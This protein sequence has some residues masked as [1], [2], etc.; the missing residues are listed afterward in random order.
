MLLSLRDCITRCNSCRIAWPRC[1]SDCT[2]CRLSARTVAWR[3]EAPSGTK[4]TGRLEKARGDSGDDEDSGDED[5]E[6]D[7]N[8]GD[9]DD[10]NRIDSRDLFSYSVSVDTP[11]VLIAESRSLHT[12][13]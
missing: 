5:E 12:S 2:F 6:D 1:F 10:D 7:D 11:P 3:H 4:K 8:D 13:Y 9:D